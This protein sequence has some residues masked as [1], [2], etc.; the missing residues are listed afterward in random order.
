MLTNAIATST[1]VR[2]ESDQVLE[3][4]RAGDERIDVPGNK[5]GCLLRVA[6]AR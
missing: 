2:I 6:T 4:E 3:V 1:D 5:C